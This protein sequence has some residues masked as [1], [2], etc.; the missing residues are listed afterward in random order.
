MI[1]PLSDLE[2]YDLLKA[3][4]PGKFS[5]DDDG[6]EDAQEF[7]EDLSGWDEIAELLGRVAMLAMPVKSMFSEDIHHVLGEV[8][9]KED[10]AQII[11]AV[12][13]EPNKGEA[14]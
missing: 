10:S 13:R 6:F 1:K 4:Y 11:A 5:D 8:T 12:K 14:L 2:M 3:A 9:I 7:A